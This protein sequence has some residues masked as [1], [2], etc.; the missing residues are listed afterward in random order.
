MAH[1]MTGLMRWRTH[2]T[3]WTF[4]GQI[5]AGTSSTVGA[6]HLGDGLG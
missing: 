3:V 5:G 2:G 4:T 6:G 1:S